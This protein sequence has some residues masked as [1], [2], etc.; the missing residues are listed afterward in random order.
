ISQPLAGEFGGV[1]FVTMGVSGFIE[2]T[3]LALFGYNIWK[4][5]DKARQE[6]EIAQS[7]SETTNANR[8]LADL[9]EVCEA[10]E[11]TGRELVA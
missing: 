4:T 6:A 1:F 2:V 9:N 11:K 5:F 3:A 8:L 10:E 7:D